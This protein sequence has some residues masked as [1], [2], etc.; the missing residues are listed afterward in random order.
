MTPYPDRP[1]AR[2]WR[3][4]LLEALSARLDGEASPAE[5]ARLDAEIARDPELRAE[6]ERLAALSAALRDLPPLSA[7]ESV[8]AGV[9][10]A[11]AAEA[12]S[13]RAALRRSAS[14][15]GAWAALF[16][17]AALGL[18]WWQ[19]EQS[20]PERL[21]GEKLARTEVSETES[22]APAASGLAAPER[23]QESARARSDAGD[24]S[25]R[26][27]AGEAAPPPAEGASEDFV[28]A[29]DPA[30]TSTGLAHDEERPRTLRESKT[31]RTLGAPSRSRGAAQADGRAAG[32]R[33]ADAS[34]PRPADEIDTAL[35]SKE[36][37]TAGAALGAELRDAPPPPAAPDAWGEPNATAA[38][39]R[40]RKLGR[41]A[42]ENS[43]GKRD[44]STSGAPP[45]E[46]T[47]RVA[48]PEGTSPADLEVL[49]RALSA[50]IAPPPAPHAAEPSAAEPGAAAPGEEADAP[51]TIVFGGG[52]QGGDPLAKAKESGIAGA[53]RAETERRAR[54]PVAG[55][56][57]GAG[58]DAGAAGRA[59]VAEDDGAPLPAEVDLAIPADRLLSAVRLVR[60]WQRTLGNDGYG[61]ASPS[62]PPERQET[63]LEIP[64]LSS[65]R[66]IGEAGPIL[67]VTILDGLSF[68]ADPETLDRFIGELVGGRGPVVASGEAAATGA[69]APPAGNAPAASS[70][71]LRVRLVVVVDRPAEPGR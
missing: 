51:E 29:A 30:A 16:L 3:E 26:V 49:A 32:A 68:D 25:A 35:E 11:I 64:D 53:P 31:G 36:E 4:E 70:M 44:A 2:D 60:R 63:A 58:V 39:L 6:S 61:A 17:V 24:L 48:V 55:A 19:L 9:R 45:P 8:L 40:F 21:A 57:L 5:A 23:H 56:E 15:S 54:E 1:D 27:P 14:R 62:Q 7:P 12:V 59:E 67:G 38:E 28:G 65:G 50:A 34:T 42:G 43:I 20:A 10:S 13:G 37:A 47:I 46:L 18:V 69:A 41:V 66:V 52:D 22:G 71:P 33:G